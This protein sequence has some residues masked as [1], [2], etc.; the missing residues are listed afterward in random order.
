MD[1]FKTVPASSML[2]PGFEPETLRLRVVCSDQLELRK[3]IV[4][5][6][7][8]DDQVPNTCYSGGGI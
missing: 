1:C 6:S 2:P 4:R 5:V 7:K 3:R 8:Q